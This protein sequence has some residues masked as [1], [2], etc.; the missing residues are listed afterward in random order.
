MS[1]TEFK[2]ILGQRH[3]QFSGKRQHDCQEFLALLLD[4][5]HSEQ[6]KM[7]PVHKGP[8]SEC[9]SMECSQ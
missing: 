5:L 8:L 1:P 6:L 9:T 3:P 2:D 7:E 4:T